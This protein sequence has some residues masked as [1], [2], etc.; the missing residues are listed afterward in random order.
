MRLS[1]EERFREIQR[2]VKSSKTIFRD[3]RL[4]EISNDYGSQDLYKIWW[5]A[6][7]RPE[8]DFEEPEIVEPLSR[9]RS[10]LARLLGRFWSVR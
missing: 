3:V 6:T 10:L 4:T 2:I 7:A 9:K 5:L 1:S 8:H